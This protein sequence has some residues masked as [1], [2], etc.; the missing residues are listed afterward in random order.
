MKKINDYSE[1]I[2]YIG[3][4]FVT[5]FILMF[6]YFFSMGGGLPFFERIKRSFNVTH[7]A[8]KMFFSE[9]GEGIAHELMT[10][11]LLIE[12]RNIIQ[13]VD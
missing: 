2:R 12:D 1:Y 3:V 4:A 8:F 9:T 13:T 10:D 11:H 7:F 5:P 6:L